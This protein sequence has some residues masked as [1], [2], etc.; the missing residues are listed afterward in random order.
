MAAAGIGLVLG[1][2]STDAVN[3]AIDASYGE[4]TGITQTVRNYGSTLGLAVLG[5]VLTT[6]FSHHLTTSLIASASRARPSTRRWATI[7]G[8]WRTAGC[9]PRRRHCAARSWTPYDTTSPPA[10]QAVLIGMGIALGASFLAALFHPGRRA[11]TGV[12]VIDSQ[13]AAVPVDADLPAAD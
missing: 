8:Q 5:T 10:A 12:E 3:R 4:V 6:V 7:G 1:P 2:A 11:Y 9:S 13:D